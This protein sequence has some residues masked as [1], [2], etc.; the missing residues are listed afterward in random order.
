MCT[1]VNMGTC[2]DMGVLPKQVYGH[3]N[4]L[5][6]CTMLIIIRVMYLCQHLELARGSRVTSLFQFHPLNLPRFTGNLHLHLQYTYLCILA[7]YLSVSMVAGGCP[8][9]QLAWP[10]RLLFLPFKDQRYM[11]D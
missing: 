6:Q 2:I 7:R 8:Q 4:V 9:V 5:C 3:T 1:C 11:R 10:A